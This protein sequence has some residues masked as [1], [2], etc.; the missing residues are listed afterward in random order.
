MAK[1]LVTGGA[2]FIGSHLVDKLVDQGHEVIVVDDLSTGNRKNVNKK[3]KLIVLDIGS[4]G[5]RKR[6][7]RLIADREYV[8]HLAA[9]PRTQYSVEKPLECNKA[10]V[11]GTLNVL[12]ACV[13]SGKLKK[14][15][16]SSSCA[17]YGL[18]ESLPIKEDAPIKHGTPYALQKY[19]QEQYIV[20]YSK[21]YKLPSVILRYFNV[22][23]TQRQTEKGSYPNVLAA[24]SK[25]K[26]K[27][28]KVYVTGDGTQTRDMVHVYDVVEANIKTMES[29]LKNAETMNIGTGVALS[30]NKMARYFKCLIKYI[31][32]RPG[33][34]KHLY[35]DVTKAEKLLNWKSKIPFEEGMKIY[36]KI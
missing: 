28:G 11:D 25:Q 18:Q 22:Y 10:N 23:G 3:A 9:I 5:A 31:P 29:D 13:L 32:A 7:V 1:I 12:N 24:F 19:I 36:F 20:L 35:S 15:I 30:I 16:H 2:G 6:L 34:A 14:L 27:D 8:F 33:E 26:K 17:I 4:D 21:L